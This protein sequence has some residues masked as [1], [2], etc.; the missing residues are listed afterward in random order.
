MDGW[1]HTGDLGSMDQRAYLRIEGRLREMIIRGGENTYTRE[2]EAVILSL[3]EVADVAVVGVDDRFWGEEVAAVVHPV[4][5]QPPSEA[6]LVALCRERLA[7]F[8]VPSRWVF[9]DTFPL[10]RLR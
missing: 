7:H 2:I 5:G 10:H 1:L 6:E 3:P 9:V 4:G 8:K